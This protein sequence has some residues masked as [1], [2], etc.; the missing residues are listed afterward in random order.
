MKNIIC[1]HCK[2]SKPNCARELCRQCYD[3]LRERSRK[4]GKEPETNEEEEEVLT[5]PLMPPIKR[6]IFKPTKNLTYQQQ[7]NTLEKE[8]CHLHQLILKTRKEK[9]VEETNTL[10]LRRTPWECFTDCDNCHSEAYV[11]CKKCP[12]CKQEPM[13]CEPCRQRLGLRKYICPTCAKG[14]DNR[15]EI[16]RELYDKSQY[17]LEDFSKAVLTK[18]GKEEVFKRVN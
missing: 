5:V 13:Y 12:L 6:T 14:D 15:I 7:I 17:V 18:W 1:R 9:R 16:E 11:D 3:L 8:I 2:Q 10:Y 4:K